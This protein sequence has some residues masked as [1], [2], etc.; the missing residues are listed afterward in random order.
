MRRLLRFQV[1]SRPWRRLSGRVAMRRAFAISFILLLTSG[2]VTSYAQSGYRVYRANLHVHTSFSFGHPKSM[3]IHNLG[4][5][6]H[7]LCVHPAQT[8]LDAGKAGLDVLG[9][10]DHG[11]S[12]D[13]NE[14]NILARTERRIA[15]NP[16]GQQINVFRGFE[17]TWKGKNQ[18]DHVNVFGTTPFT[19]VQ[20]FNK[21]KLTEFVTTLPDLYAW[22]K[23]AQ[24]TAGYGP[25]PVAQ[26]NHIFWG[27]HLEAF[28]NA[29]EDLDDIF[30]LAE[31]GCGESPLPYHVG[32]NLESVKWGSN[33]TNSERYYQMALQAGWHVSPSIGVDNQ[34][35]IARH[36]RRCHTGIWAPQ[37]ATR[38]QIVDAIR[39][40]RVF[41]SEDAD[42]QLN[43]TVTVDGTEYVMGSRIAVEA[44]EGRGRLCIDLLDSDG[45]RPDDIRIVDRC[46]HSALGDRN[47]G[48]G[49]QELHWISSEL[50]KSSFPLTCTLA[51]RQGECYYIKVRLPAGFSKVKVYSS[52]VWFVEAMPNAGQIA[53]SV[54][55]GSTGNR[56]P[57][58]GVEASGQTVVTDGQGA[59]RIVGLPPGPALLTI[60]AARYAT[61]TASAEV[62]AGSVLSL[63]VV[64]QPESA[65]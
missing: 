50:R 56:V 13:P 63:D 46:G 40:R 44:S 51:Y 48:T 60:S 16:S 37:N 6:D 62:Q 7:L 42:C 45:D 59:A 34:L 4:T 31:I 30:C 25:R 3:D 47:G 58:A 11:G 12:L 33:P 18:S 64:L 38:S 14:W 55:D 9:I 15:A 52:P 19:D 20:Q 22:L 17:W 61:C 2:A 27:T 28:K 29:D 32:S 36:A 65:P 26:F 8:V 49:L 57:D 1:G 23:S 41:A 54:S 39:S 43:Y 24:T 5:L 53:V 35:R 10:S 21:G